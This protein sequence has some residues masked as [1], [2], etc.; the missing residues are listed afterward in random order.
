MLSKGLVDLLIGKVFLTD[1]N[2]L[3]SQL[4]P[5][6]ILISTKE[7]LVALKAAKHVAKNW[8]A[9]VFAAGGRIPSV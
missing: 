1:K 4:V 3:L 8:L 7:I 9:F 2:N 6:N 5:E